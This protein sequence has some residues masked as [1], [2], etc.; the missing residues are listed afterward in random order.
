MTAS[1]A[2][3]DA[4]NKTTITAPANEPVIILT[5]EFDAPRELVYAMHTRPEHVKRWWGPSY[6]TLSICEIDLR[7]GGE[8]RYVFAKGAGPG[9][10][11]KG[12]YR[13]VVPPERLVYTFIFDVEHIRDHPALVTATFEERDGKTTLTQTTRH[14]TFEARDGHLNSGMEAG[15]KETM[16]RLE[17]LLATM[18]T[19]LVLTRIFDAPRELVFKAWTERDR[20]ARWWS[21]KGFTNPVCEIDVR[22]GGKIKI[23]MRGPDGAIHPMEGEFK[24][25][26]APERLVFRAWALNQRGERMFEMETTVIFAER[27]GKTE[28]KFETRAVKVTGEAAGPLSGMTQ[29]WT[30]SLERLKAE[31]EG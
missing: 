4:K 30:E 19:Q 16:D 13:E 24:E 14:D 5:R 10:T 15:A 17:E 1:N 22:P 9:M 26:V 7:P 27:G 18:P 3:T 8:W 31:V 11:F 29:G 28:M 21:P 23:H 6:I 2:S 25:I 20:V 12:V